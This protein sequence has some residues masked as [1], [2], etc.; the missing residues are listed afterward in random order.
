MN[1]ELES[2]FEICDTIIQNCDIDFVLLQTFQMDSSFFQNYDK[3][4]VVRCSKST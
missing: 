3:T 1:K 2:I 4:R